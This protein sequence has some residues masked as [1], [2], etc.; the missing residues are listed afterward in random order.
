MLSKT[1]RRYARRIS[2]K[3]PAAGCLSH[4]PVRV[5]DLSTSG[6]RVHHDF[7]LMLQPGKKFHLEFSCEGES[8]MVPCTV[9]RARLEMTDSR[10]L[11]YTSGVHFVDVDTQTAEKLW[12]VIAGLAMDDLAHESSAAPVLEFSIVTP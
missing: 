11:V 8:L 10:E 3:P 6:A 12:A 1:D 2:L 7:P 4:F 9:A 5:V